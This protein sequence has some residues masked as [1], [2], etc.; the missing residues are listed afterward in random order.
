M[1]V[2]SQTSPPTS[3]SP[4]EIANADV[5][6]G[7]SQRSLESL[8]S[9]MS[10]IRRVRN[11]I[12][13]ITQFP[14]EILISILDLSIGEYG[15]L[16]RIQKLES[17]CQQW[18]QVFENTPSFW[19]YINCNVHVDLVRKAV[20]LSNP[21]PVTLSFNEQT[22]PI[23]NRPHNF[24]EEVV[25]PTV[26]RC[27]ELDLSL[28]APES[29]R[30][31]GA[32][33]APLLERLRLGMFNSEGQL[34]VLEP[35]IL[36]RG[37]APKLTFVVFRGRMAIDW[38]PCT[39]NDLRS[40]SVRHMRDGGP[41]ISAL[42][43]LLSNTPALEYLDLELD[44]ATLGAPPGDFH[45]INL[46]YLRTL[47]LGGLPDLAAGHL[48][49]R[50][51]CPKCVNFSIDLGPDPVS[52]STFV[53]AMER[54]LQAVNSASKITPGIVRLA[55]SQLT[56][57]RFFCQGHSTTYPASCQVSLFLPEWLTEEQLSYISDTIT[58][59]LVNF[60]VDVNWYSQ[61]T[62]AVE[63]W[64]EFLSTLPRVTGLTIYFGGALDSIIQYLSTPRWE[65]GQTRWPH[66]QLATL[67][68]TEECE[69]HL[70]QLLRMVRRRYA[71]EAEGDQSDIEPPA[72]LTMLSIYV[73]SEET[74]DEEIWAEIQKIVGEDNTEIERPDGHWTTLP[75]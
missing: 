73:D 59:R 30:S 70:G 49:S 46:P 20:K 57:N 31:L 16:P 26:E 24:W 27:R 32:L 68:I 64:L 11:S 1:P 50:I 15:R 41:S 28:R 60:E 69:A 65:A 67:D 5:L 17:V 35:V 54:S 14:L 45:T 63:S 40:L 9:Q 23:G 6:L 12:F 44:Q 53:A 56:S 22:E 55:F 51:L 29:L 62:N 2:C 7:D 18:R 33:K 52:Q 47:E 8:R 58:N 71:S 10:N 3:F 37:D 19:I 74:F 34:E 4:E 61:S 13:P 36:F 43:A 21:A 38:R 75:P 48:M 25:V 72:P 39:F 42:M 66:P